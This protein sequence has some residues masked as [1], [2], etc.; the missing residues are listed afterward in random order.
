MFDPK[1]EGF[2]NLRY[3]DVKKNVLI[4][5]GHLVMFGL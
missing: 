4:Y 1:K 5:I 3:E 2:G